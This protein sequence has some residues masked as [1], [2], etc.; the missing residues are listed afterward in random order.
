M[1]QPFKGKPPRLT[2]VFQRDICPVYF[3]TFCTLHRRQALANDPVHRA[4]RAYAEAGNTKANVAVGRYVIMPDHVHLFVQG[5]DGFDLGIWIR[6]LKRF[7]APG[8]EA[9]VHGVT[10]TTSATPRRILPKLW[11]PGFFDHL[12]RSSESYERKWHYVRENPVR[13]GLS[14]R[15]EDWPYQ[16]EVVSIDRV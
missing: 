1:T 13:A 11:Q 6:G 3:V 14:V 16:G 8:V 7:M 9:V 2:Q 5:D 4:F 15:A 12:L 10:G